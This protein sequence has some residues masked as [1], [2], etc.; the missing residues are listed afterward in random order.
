M[1]GSDIDDHQDGVSV[2]DSIPDDEVDTSISHDLLQEPQD[3]QSVG[4]SDDHQSEGGSVGAADDHQSE[5]G[6]VGATDDHQD[7]V[8]VGDSIPDEESGGNSSMDERNSP[9]RT[10]TPDEEVVVP[11]DDMVEPVGRKNPTA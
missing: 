9:S 2:G 10:A 6:S 8:S 1:G 5:G 4:A 11:I 3:V 7:G